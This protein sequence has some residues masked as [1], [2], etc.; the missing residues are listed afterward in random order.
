MDAAFEILKRN[1]EKLAKIDQTKKTWASVSEINSYLGC[2]RKWALDVKYPTPKRGNLVLGSA[3][4]HALET[5]YNYV[6]DTI[7]SVDEMEMEQKSFCVEEAKRYVDK[8][9]EESPELASEMLGQDE[10]LSNM[11]ETYIDYANKNDDFTV[12][13]TEL[14]IIEEVAPGVLFKAFI[15]G[16]AV[17][18]EG[19]Y[20]I[21]E[22]KTAKVVSQEHLDKDL[23][24]SAY[25]AV[26]EKHLEIPIQG[27]IYNQ[28]KKKIPSE[29][30]F[31]KDGSVS[32]AA[33]DTTV[34]KFA[35]AL[36]VAFTSKGIEIPDKYKS[37]VAELYETEKEFMMRTFWF[38]TAAEKKNTIEFL[39]KIIKE[40]KWMRE[41]PIS[42]CYPN[43]SKDCGWKCD[44]KDLCLRLNRGEALPEPIKIKIALE[45][46]EEEITGEE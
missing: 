9:L 11:V 5:F 36:N 37:K 43:P 10:L 21:L 17:D 31:L 34:A 42:S 25:I 41:Q 14:L 4:H 45:G 22:H 33:C 29:P 3:F 27:V 39:A 8:A 23:Q 2:Q 30:K 44:N 46:P 15:D 1:K 35:N 19:Q 26:A 28:A 32:M 38:R 6:P 12:I 7:G 24:I 20:W 40:I 16:L 13:A 18:K